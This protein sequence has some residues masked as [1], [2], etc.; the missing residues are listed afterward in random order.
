M[1]VCEGI[2][3]T[4]EVLINAPKMN[5]LKQIGVNK[6]LKID[7]VLRGFGAKRPS[8]VPVTT[9]AL[10]EIEK[11]VYQGLKEYGFRKYGRTLH[12][13]V[14]EDISQVINFQAGR[15][16]D[17]MAG[18]FCVNLGIRVPECVDRQF[19]P[20]EPLGK[21]YREY[22]CNL[23]SRL[24]KKRVGEDVW[25]AFGSDN[26]K[27]GHQI[28]KL[29]K[30]TVLPVF[31]LLNSR[32]AILEHRRDYKAF[33]QLNSNLVLLEEAM[34]Y[35]HIGDMDT[36]KRLF[37]EYYDNCVKEY[38]YLRVHGRKEWMNKGERMTY[39]DQFGVIQDITA[40]KSGYITMFD[41]NHGHIDYLDDLSSKLGFR[42]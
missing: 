20:T 13:F 26:E 31:D 23:R 42:G 14:S 7:W 33:D 21:Y 37:Q 28:L 10:D 27:I 19:Q 9:V 8:N 39:M 29:L 38:E 35:G 2:N 32:E 34:I 41:A 22:D 25:F 17:G 12:R 30:E 5:L 16:A 18:I 15:P 36:S 24:G 1:S 6:R 11:T 3:A 4:P 40:S